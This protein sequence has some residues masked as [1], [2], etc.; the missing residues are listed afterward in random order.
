MD[1]PDNF[2]KLR[3]DDE[4]AGE[5]ARR[6][7][8]PLYVYDLNHL[9]RR[10][11][12]ILAVAEK[13]DVRPFYAMKANANRDVL[14]TVK[15]MGFG[16]DT[17]SIGEVAAALKAGFSPA[18]IAYDGNNVADDEFRAVHERG[19]HV[20]VDSLSQLDRFGSLFPGAAASVRLNP[21][22][23]AGHHGYVVTGGPKSK[24]GIGPE[25]IPEIHAIAARRGITID[26]LHLHIGS[27][28]SDPE[29]YLRAMDFLI[30]TSRRFAD[31]R[32]L[33]FG[34]G[35]GIPYRPT[36]AEFAW[37]PFLEAAAKKLA[38]LRKELHVR[39]LECRIQPGR[40]LVAE[41]GTL[42]VT[43]T[44][45]K[46]AAAHTFVGVDS[47]MNHL[48]RPALY[49]AWHEIVNLTGRDRPKERYTIVGNICESSDVLG[50]DRLLHRVS[51]GD[52]LAIRDAGA[53]GFAMASNY[54]LRP[55][56]AEAVIDGKDL[57]LSRRRETIDELSG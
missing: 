18:A 37:S 10:G 16:V 8:T 1:R 9:R 14:A 45:V 50:A 22:I 17:V 38:A 35:F 20:N 32:I 25:E 27:G 46:R 56:P 15:A 36:D 12:D 21:A 13:L 47:G 19:V 26:G 34:G 2:E 11:E 54:N 40:Y 7:A 39:P 3:I 33:D 48:L 6:F 42:L 31:L 52:L 49:E 53:Y 23:G 29:P 4:L 43:V 51:E 24:F 44:A 30:E 28:F 5:A 55:R 41:A 57:R